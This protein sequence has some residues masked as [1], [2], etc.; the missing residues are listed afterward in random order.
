MCGILG[1]VDFSRRP[2]DPHQVVEMT[3]SLRHRG[4]DGYGYVH[5]DTRAGK[6]A[7]WQDTPPSGSDLEAA[8]VAFGHRRLSILDLED[9][10]QPMTNEDGT[11]W[12]TYNGEIYNAGDLRSELTQ[13]GHVFQT[14]HSDT[15]VLI[16]AYEEWGSRSVERLRGMFAYAIVDMRRGRLFLAR[17]RVGQKPLYYTTVGSR[18]LFASELKALLVDPSVRREIEPTA[19]ADYFHFGYIPS[20]KTVFRGV[21]KMRPAHFLEVDLQNPDTIDPDAENRYWRLTFSPDR[22]VAHADWVQRLEDALTDAVRVRMAS[23][24]PLGAFLSGGLDS[25]AVVSKMNQ[26]SVDAVSTF[27]IGFEEER[28]NEAPHARQI[29]ELFGTKHTEQTVKPDAVAVISLLA[30]QFDEPFADFSAVPTHYVCQ[31]ARKHLTVALSGDGGDEALSGYNRYRKFDEVGRFVNWMPTFLRRTLFGAIASA[32]PTTVRGN[33]FASFASESGGGRYARLVGMGPWKKMMSPDLLSQVRDYDPLERIRNLWDNAAPNDPVARMQAVDIESYMP[34]DTLT[35]VD[36]ASMMNS[37]EVR[38]P[39]L[40]HHLLETVAR[41]PGDENVDGRGGKALLRDLLRP[42]V[43]DDVLNRPKRGFTLPLETWLRA[44]LADELD[45]MF[46]H[47]GSFLG[48][49]ASISQA[50]STLTAHRA[51]LK[52]LAGPLWQLYFLEHWSRAYL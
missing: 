31:A 26:G 22:S 21:H 33:S 42:Y 29:A 10:T 47:P 28:F 16:H 50:R 36:R 4:P 23:D 48:S 46:T 7:F 35:K 24:V 8:T 15:E 52:N 19:I 6:A 44:D 30:T 12:V 37:L 5:L 13:L 43:G 14:D 18:L 38:S 11:V 45:E 40:D 9:G 49:A 3:D 27:T 41:I 20:P 32:L 17:D 39:F 25:A 51:G 34:E 1:I 2:I